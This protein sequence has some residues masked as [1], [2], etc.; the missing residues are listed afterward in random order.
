MSSKYQTETLVKCFIIFVPPSMY[1]KNS[2]NT[3]YD[4]VTIFFCVSFYSV[5]VSLTVC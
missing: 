3:V 1:T 2:V 5:I 4:L